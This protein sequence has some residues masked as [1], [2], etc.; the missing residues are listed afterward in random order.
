LVFS[1]RVTFFRL[2]FAA[3]ACGGNDEH[4]AGRARPRPV[5]PPAYPL[6]PC[7]PFGLS[8]TDGPMA[9]L[10]APLLAAV[11]EVVAAVPRGSIEL[12]PLAAP[13][14]GA[15]TAAVLRYVHDGLPL[16]GIYGRADQIDGRPFVHEPA[17]RWDLLRPG[18]DGGS[19][20][21]REAAA[22]RLAQSFDVHRAGAIA[23][24]EAC[25]WPDGE[26]LRP[27]WELELEAGGE[28]VRGFVGGGL[29][30]LT[31]FR[32]APVGF[33]AKG[34][35]RLAKGEGGVGLADV[36]LDGSFDGSGYL[37]GPHF[38]TIVPKSIEPAFS[39]DL[40]FAFEP[41]DP[42]FAQATAFAHAERMLQWLTLPE[43]SYEFDLGCAPIS[44]E[45][46]AVFGRGDVNNAR[47]V[48]AVETDDGKP[49][50]RIGDGDGRALMNLALDFDVIS[51]ELGHHVVYRAVKDTDD[52]ESVV[53]H[54]AL[55]DYLN[56]AM[57]GDAC[58]GESI[59]PIG[60]DWCEVASRCLRTGD[61]LLNL[62]QPD[63]PRDT[64]RR[65]QVLSGLLWSLRARLGDELTT[66]LVFKA[67]EFL[68]PRSSYRDFV[69]ALLLADAER[70]AGQ[71]ACGIH[72]A[73]VERGLGAR[74][75]D[76][77]CESYAQPRQ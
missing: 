2:V 49:A 8:L 27:A 25:W 33:D 71:N 66:P 18:G 56:F 67:I 57:T 1:A 9:R 30:G 19:W 3:S 29:E 23:K 47:Y 54:E 45:I 28:R 77:A 73:A 31:V 69:V 5:L 34:S 75:A 7:T 42:R 53:I 17:L 20:P 59:C 12:R 35:I 74:I 52:Y 40:T 36:M 16:C 60:S 44:L 24:A 21:A 55:A 32:A 4:A 48:P 76:L 72:A 70:N 65:S 61:N 62:A 11:D 64:H 38:R 15:G 26:L 22:D 51:H 68:L 13:S 14:M 6:S 46:H 10:S 63:L 50:I 58:L 43:H 41:Q 39:P 37:R